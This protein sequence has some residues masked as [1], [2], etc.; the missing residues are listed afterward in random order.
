LIGVSSATGDRS[1]TLATVAQVRGS[2][3]LQSIT[4]EP[5]TAPALTVGLPPPA[6]TVALAR[7][8]AHART[9]P[10]IE[11]G[12]NLTGEIEWLRICA[13]PTELRGMLM[14]AYPV[15]PSATK[16][17][18]QPTRLLRRWAISRCTRACLSDDD[19]DQKPHEHFGLHPPLIEPKPIGPAGAVAGLEPTELP[20]DAVEALGVVA[21]ETGVL[22]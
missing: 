14:A 12:L 2:L 17:A 18:I 1:S 19:T 21:V 16:S 20:V 22:E 9:L 10:P 6:R 8:I 4:Y 15:P 7:T 13:D 3:V 5:G 11:L